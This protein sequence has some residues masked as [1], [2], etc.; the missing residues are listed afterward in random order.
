MALCAKKVARRSPEKIVLRKYQ[1]IVVRVNMFLLVVLR[2]AI[3][4]E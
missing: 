2:R 1:C 4:H 3:C